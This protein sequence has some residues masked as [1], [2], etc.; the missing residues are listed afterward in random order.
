[1]GLNLRAIS[2]QITIVLNF[3]FMLNPLIRERG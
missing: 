2:L 1:M 3:Y